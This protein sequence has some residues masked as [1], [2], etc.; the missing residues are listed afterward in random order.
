M[1]LTK[2]KK[3]DSSVKN[4]FLFFQINTLDALFE[5]K[6]IMSYVLSIDFQKSLA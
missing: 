5:P 6:T 4:E 2:K 1:K 3:M